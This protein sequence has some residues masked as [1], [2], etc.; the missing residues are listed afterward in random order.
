MRIGSLLL[1][2][3]QVRDDEGLGWDPV[4]MMRAA[5]RVLAGTEQQAWDRWHGL[6]ADAARAWREAGVAGPDVDRWVEL[7]LPPDDLAVLTMPVADGGAGLPVAAVP[8][9]CEAISLGGDP[10]DDVVTRVV[11]WRSMGLPDDAAVG[12]L[13]PVMFDRQPSDVAPWL[14]AGFTAEDI[15]VWEAEDL[16]RAT[17]WRDAGFTSRQARDLLSAD[18]AVTPDEAQAFD[19]AGIESRSRLRWVAAGFSAQEARAWTDLGIVASEARVWRSLR[20]G[21][22]VAHAQRASGATGT[23]PSGWE[24]GWAA[25]GS[26]RDDM[27]F[28]VVD[29]PG[30]RGQ[31]AAESLD[32]MWDVPRG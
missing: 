6:Q 23:L 26:E 5:Q 17:R 9:W 31:T 8:Q 11:A 3:R 20:L 24:G 19:A 30:T 21:P 27:N 7:G 15:A 1:V 22:D 13:A 28:G 2:I 4:A 18:P 32:P 16:P 29:P 12:R 14:R 10:R 25:M